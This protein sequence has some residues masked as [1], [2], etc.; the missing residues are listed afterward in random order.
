MKEKN[1]TTKNQ[2]TFSLEDQ[3]LL[4]EEKQNDTTLTEEERKKRSERYN[5]LSTEIF[6][7][8]QDEITSTY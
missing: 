6:Q 8:S 3:Y 2:D 1:T 4:A 7:P 5:R